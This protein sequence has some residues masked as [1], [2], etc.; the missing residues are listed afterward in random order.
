ME[1]IQFRYGSDNLAY[2]VCGPRR[3]LAVDGGAVGEI[4]AFLRRRRLELACVVNT[5][6]H[7][8]HTA[9]TEELVR[10]SGAEYLDNGRLRADG[11][12]YVDEEPVRVLHTPGHTLDCLTFVAGKALITGDTLFNGTVGNCFSGD[13]RGFH[14]SICRLSR[15]P[16]DTR[17]YAGHD[18]VRESIAFA[19]SL[20]PQNPDLD[21]YLARYRPDHVVSTLGEERR[22]NPYLR[23][24]EPSL[25]E[26]MRRK[27]L[28]AD[29][30]YQRWVA[31]M[32]L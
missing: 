32:G 24:N 31:L 5:H 23:C 27:G 22:V 21:R 26:V 15:F 25:V 2:L 13:L 29:T 8:D 16:D 9:G 1:I 12:V 17:I 28:A 4:L 20:E 7:P 11:A 18:Y 10:R 19:R 3:A 6:A 14:D 30:P